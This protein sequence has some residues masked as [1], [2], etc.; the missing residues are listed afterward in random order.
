MNWKLYH[1][2]ITMNPN[3][4]RYDIYSFIKL[5]ANYFNI[6]K[7][8]EDCMIYRFNQTWDLQSDLYAKTKYEDVII[9]ILLFTNE[10]DCKNEL[11]NVEPYVLELYKKVDYDKH[12]TA[13]YKV[14]GTLKTINNIN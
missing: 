5:T 3:H 10:Y 14:L 12:I 11:L 4:I 1:A 13:I 2:S 9:G 8:H 6:S 7:F